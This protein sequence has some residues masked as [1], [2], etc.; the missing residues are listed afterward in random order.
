[1]F[2]EWMITI[3]HKTLS[4]VTGVVKVDT[5]EDL[6]EVLGESKECTDSPTKAMACLHRHPMTII[7]L[8]QQMQELSVKTIRHQAETVLLREASAITG[9]PDP[10]SHRRTHSNTLALDPVVKEAS[11]TSSGDLSL[12]IRVRARDLALKWASK[13]V[14]RTPYVAMVILRK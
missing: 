10:H 7:Q 12:A 9:V 14:T 2:V 4:S 11:Q 13:V 5:E 8:H 1:M 6:L 3:L